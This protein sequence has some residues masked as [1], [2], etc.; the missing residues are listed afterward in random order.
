MRDKNMKQSLEATRSIPS[1]P[2]AWAVP[3]RKDPQ[4]RHSMSRGFPLW[5]AKA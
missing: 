2:L 1:G 5:Q 3:L 4:G